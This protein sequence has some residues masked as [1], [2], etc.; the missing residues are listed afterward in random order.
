M[1]HLQCEEKPL[2]LEI[3][4]NPGAYASKCPYNG[5]PEPQTCK[6]RT[7]N[8]SQQSFAPNPEPKL[9]VC[10]TPS[11]MD[12]LNLQLQHANLFKVEEARRR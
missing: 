4:T 11:R 5:S 6:N 8:G 3:R 1:R 7:E 9:T 2:L 10:K 12:R